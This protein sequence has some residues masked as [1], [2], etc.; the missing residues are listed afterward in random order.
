MSRSASVSSPLCAWPSGFPASQGAVRHYRVR[1][2]HTEVGGEPGGQGHQACQGQGTRR[3]GRRHTVGP[4]ALRHRDRCARRHE[5][6]RRSRPQ[7]LPPGDLPSAGGP[8]QGRTHLR[9]GTRGGLHRLHGV[10]AR[11][12]PGGTGG[13]HGHR[14]HRD[15]GHGAG[16][17][18]G[19]RGHRGARLAG[20]TTTRPWRHGPTCPS[21]GWKTT[22]SRPRP[23]QSPQRQPS[24]ARPPATGIDAATETA[25]FDE[26]PETPEATPEPLVERPSARSRS[27]FEPLDGEEP[28]SVT[29]TRPP[30]SRAAP[31]TGPP[32]PSRSRTSRAIRARSRTSR[33]VQ[34][35]TV[36]AGGHHLRRDGRRRVRALGHGGRP[37]K[38]RR[39]PPRSR[40]SRRRRTGA[41][42]RG[43]RDHGH[44]RAGR[45]RRGRQGRR[46]RPSAA[47][48]DSDHDDFDPIDAGH[49]DKPE[50]PPRPTRPPRPRTPQTTQPCRTSAS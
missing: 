28:P 9:R 47:D 26:V 7:A 32:P 35:R 23:P 4:D 3:S 30:R 46:T 37:P 43:P 15:P 21:R 48:E 2:L 44:R 12:R 25:R 45:R 1:G 18:R 16:G 49:E 6:L 20:R 34:A 5:R 41:R 29:R 24:R 13:Q 40:T 50:R 31:R 10:P 17:I 42:R 22:I 11:H 38:P 33:V 27:L 39:H 8:R 19:R 14:V 36:R